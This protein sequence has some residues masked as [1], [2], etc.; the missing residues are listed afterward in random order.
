M[1]RWWRVAGA[2]LMNLPLGALYAW[3]IFVLPLEKEFRVD[4]HA[5]V[6]G[7]HDR[8]LRLRTELH[9]GRTIAGQEGAVLD[10]RRGI[11]PVQ[12]RVGPRDLREGPYIAVSHDGVVLG[13]AAGFG[14]ATPIPSCRSGSPIAGDWRWDS[15]WRGTAAGPSSSPSSEKPMLTAF[16]WRDTFPV[17][18]DRV[19]RRDDARCVHSCGNPPA[20]W[21]P[22]G[23]VP[24]AASAKVTASR[25]EYLPG[26]V[27]KTPAFY[28][29]GSHT[30]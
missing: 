23:W 5:D 28:F 11:G 7:L 13:S 2:L 22:A 25:H 26:E 12:P 6:L 17:P 15:P 16:G 27:V 29:C 14:Y 21:K 20:G 9:R 24:A 3:S 4:A 30:P 1:N 10:L 18:W 8:R 19:P